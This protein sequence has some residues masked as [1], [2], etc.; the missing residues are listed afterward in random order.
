M[1]FFFDTNIPVFVLRDKEN[2]HR[3]D[4]V[5]VAARRIPRT[6][7]SQPH[8]TEDPNKTKNYKEAPGDY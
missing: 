7:L 4:Q 6:Q 2:I 3:H 1:S 8:F 5:Q